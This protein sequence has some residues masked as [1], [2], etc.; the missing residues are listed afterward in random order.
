M[1]LARLSMRA[2]GLSARRPR[3]TLSVLK[4]FEGH[5]RTAEE[6][7]VRERERAIKE[8]EEAA[9]APARAAMDAKELQRSMAKNLAQLELRKGLERQAKLRE[10]AMLRKHLE[11]GGFRGD[12]RLKAMVTT[13]NVHTV[14]EYHAKFHAD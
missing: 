10:E 3:A 7:F 9:E 4:D 12:E 5:G 11:N 6:L 13:R 8:C 14:A 2:A 1:L